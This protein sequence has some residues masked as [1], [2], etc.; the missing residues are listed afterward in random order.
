M[1]DENTTPQGDTQ[2]ADNAPDAAKNTDAAADTQDQVQTVPYERF[3]EVI[4][5]MRE[6][7]KQL[8]AQEKQQEA[9][10]QQQLAEQGKY[11][12][13][14]KE[15]QEK[16]DAAQQQ[17]V[18]YA[19][20]AA[21]AQAGFIDPADAV[22][23]IDRSKIVADDLGTVEALISELAEAKPHLLRQSGP[24]RPQLPSLPALNASDT[25]TLTREDVAKMSPAEVQARI[26]EIK[27]AMKTWR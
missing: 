15:W 12:E 4:K 9:Q 24:Q 21:A 19:V 20:K 18:S 8:Q 13:L 1:T 26:N 16:H 27:A 22:A 2:Q 6:Y 25:K 17:L 11:Q 5:K 23:L 3:A 14:A 10:R 7:E